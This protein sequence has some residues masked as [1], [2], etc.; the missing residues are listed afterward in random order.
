MTNRSQ[1]ILRAVLAMIGTIIGAGLFGLPAMFSRLG[2]VQGSLL[3]LLLT[4]IV[5]MTHLLLVD[6]VLVETTKHRLP[7]LVRRWLGSWGGSFSHLL[8]PAQIIGADIAYILLG[9]AFFDLLFRQV[10]LRIDVFWWQLFFWVLVAATVYRNLAFVARVEAWATWA[11]LA[12][13]ILLTIVV[14]PAWAPIPVFPNLGGWVLGFGVVLFA[15][16]GNTVVAEAVEIVGRRRKAA[17]YAVT[18]GT[19][20]SAFVSWGFGIKMYLAT[21]G[22]FSDALSYLNVIP[23]AWLWLLPVFGLLAVATS[24]ITS[25]EDFQ[26]SL[27]YDLGWDERASWAVVAGA[28]LAVSLILKQ[29]FIVIAS[30][31]GAVFIGANGLLITLAAARMGA[32]KRSR[33]VLTGGAV[34]AC[35]YGIGIIHALLLPML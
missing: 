16:T 22:A 9:G 7:G 27:M 23:P 32:K 14:R 17:F 8:Y 29:E 25:T 20:V 10:G 18:C 35:A 19:L 11:L 28:P 12:S 13:L 34:C 26:A 33:W 30:F 24:F 2:I 5:L 4:G 15:L 6:L 3:F 31:V 21:G 1:T